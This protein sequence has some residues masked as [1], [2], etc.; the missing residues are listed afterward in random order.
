[1]ANIHELYTFAAM[2]GVNI[3]EACLY[4]SAMEGLG[5]YSGSVTARAASYW[6]KG[7]RNPKQESLAI[8]EMALID[9]AGE[10]G[11][12]PVGSKGEAHKLGVKKLL[13]RMK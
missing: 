6:R 11:T 10:K 2:T 7:K 3:G 9:L 4:T 8:L 13:R 5:Q 1:M 12:L